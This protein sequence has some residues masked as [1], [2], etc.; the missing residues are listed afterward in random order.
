M[1]ALLQ[2][3]VCNLMNPALPKG[4][5]YL[6]HVLMY[7]ESVFKDSTVKCFSSIL[8]HLL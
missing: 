7:D 8:V 2:S 1:M 4:D 6:N 3:R 5:I